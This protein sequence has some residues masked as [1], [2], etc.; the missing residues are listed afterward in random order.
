MAAT[1]YTPISLYYSTT[2]AAAPT[3][4]NLVNGELA[5]N[6]TDGKLYYKDNTGTVKVIAGA[7]GAADAGLLHRPLRQPGTG[8]NGRAQ[9][10]GGHGA[11]RARA[12]R[13]L[14]LVVARSHRRPA[15]RGRDRAL[16]DSV[17]QA[18]WA[19]AARRRTQSLARGCNPL[20]VEGRSGRAGRRSAFVAARPRPSRIDR[21]AGEPG[22]LLGRRHQGRD[23]PRTCDPLARR[24]R[25]TGRRYR[26][27]SRPGERRTLVPT[28]CCFGREG[29]LG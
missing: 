5:I 14:W 29:L 20:D 8:R 19:C 10:E 3:A 23:P 25:K 6:I 16:V 18:I 1:G 4:G 11:C 28:P 15:G 7:G 9:P 17:A 22:R 2:A 26:R 21:F 24:E 13:G 12:G 27:R